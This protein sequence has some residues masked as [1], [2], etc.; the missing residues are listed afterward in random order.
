MELTKRRML[1]TVGVAATG[2]ASADIVAAEATPQGE[3]KSNERPSR[4]FGIYNNS[5]DR[6]ELSV[7]VILN[8][9]ESV[10]KEF[11]LRGLNENTLDNSSETRFQG[12]ILIPAEG[13]RETRLRVSDQQGQLVETVVD[14][15]GKNID[16]QTRIWAKVRPSGEI[17]VKEATR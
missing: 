5:S 8:S 12:D 1:Q 10:S 7:S 14:M 16:D 3:I 4:N 2:V 15:E 13:V 6:K 11:D 9:S 17:V